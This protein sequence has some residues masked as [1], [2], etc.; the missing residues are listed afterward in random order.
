MWIARL[1][2][3][4]CEPVRTCMIKH[5]KLI[6]ASWF[7]AVLKKV[8]SDFVSR[9]LEP[10]TSS[11]RRG[12]TGSHQVVTVWLRA[13]MVIVRIPEAGSHV[14]TIDRK[15]PNFCCVHY[16]GPRPAACGLS[17]KDFENWV[18]ATGLPKKLS[19]QNIGVNFRIGRIDGIILGLS[20]QHATQPRR[21]GA[22]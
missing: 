7:K 14:N 1:R 4:L 12:Q 6:E 3:F 16:A 22:S 20:G 10:I 19:A 5:H 15:Q 11:L 17:P 13:E 8:A 2:S 21:G 9:L 18:T